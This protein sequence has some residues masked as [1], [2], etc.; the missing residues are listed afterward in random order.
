MPQLYE[1]LPFQDGNIQSQQTL[2]SPPTMTDH[3]V[4]RWI[5]A[6]NNCVV[7]CGIS[8]ATLFNKFQMTSKNFTYGFTIC[9]GQHD[10]P[11]ATYDVVFNKLEQ[12]RM[13]NTSIIHSGV[14]LQ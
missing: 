4:K 12:Y 11:S 13:Y 1:G 10:I 9:H 14:E 6:K 8:S 7:Q 3:N 5:D 2:Q